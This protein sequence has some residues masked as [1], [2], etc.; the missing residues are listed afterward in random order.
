[1]GNLARRWG[2]AALIV[3]MSGCQAAPPA[4]RDP[5]TA[6]GEVIALSGGEGG[7]SHACFTCHGLDGSG[8]GQAAPRLAGLDAGYLQRQLEAYG[9]GRRRHKPMRAVTMKLTAQDRRAVAAYYAALP[10]RPS[11]GSARQTDGAALY[12]SGDPG[13]GL[14]ACA[15]CHGP[16][17]QGGGPAN[18]ALAGQPAAYVVDQL[19][20]WKAGE[21]RNDPRG[22][23]MTISQRLTDREIDAL[24][25]YVQGLSGSP[26]PASADAEASPP[27]RRPDQ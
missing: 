26:A 12:L 18:P 13:R 8:D 19:K 17:G 22:T 3:F 25:Q 10:W 20:Q 5:F 4:E 9:D 24:A 11:V 1:M 2:P 14:Q 6:T 23:M 27:E 21:R 16:S 7:A 15:A